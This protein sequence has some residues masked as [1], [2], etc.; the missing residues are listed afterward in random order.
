MDELRK[1]RENLPEGYRTLEAA[2]R[3]LGIT[4]PQMYRYETGRRRIPAERCKAFAAATGIPVEL[5]RPDV[6]GP[7]TQ[8]KPR[9]KAAAITAS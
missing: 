5:L 7:P 9:A 1:W 2:G 3:L 4:G 6:F 8:P